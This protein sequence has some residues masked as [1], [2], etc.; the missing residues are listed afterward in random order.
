MTADSDP[1]S[2]TSTAPVRP[3]VTPK[4]MAADLAAAAQRRREAA[5]A[6]APQ[7]EGAS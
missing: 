1:A 7:A 5:E 3:V 4:V 2:E 6:G